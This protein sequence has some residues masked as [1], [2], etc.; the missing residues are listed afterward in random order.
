MGARRSRSR[1]RSLILLGASGHGRVVADVARRSGLFHVRGFIDDAPSKAGRPFDG[2]PVLGD[3]RDLPR[4]ARRLK[5]AVIVAIGANAARAA[6]AEAVEAAGLELA[7]A[8]HPSAVVAEGARLGP[9]SVVMAGAVL[10][11][12]VVVG[13]NAIVNTGATVDH[14]CI[15]ADAVHVSP[16]AHLAGQV[17]VGRE[18][19]IG[20]GAAVIQKVRIG[21]RSI[22]GA[23]AVVIRDVPPDS[24]V[25]GNPARPIAP[26]SRNQVHE[27]R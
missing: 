21:A 11:P 20:I 26:R 18:A 13:G 27:A 19:H 22:V 4:V 8:V 2:L 5:A 14:D 23:G 7:T 24:T 9:G 6:A 1:R 3:S 10:N 25:V 15:L 16:G 12:G 17:R